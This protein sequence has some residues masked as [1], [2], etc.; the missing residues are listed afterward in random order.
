MD[1]VKAIGQSS[2]V[3]DHHHT[4]ALLLGRAEQHI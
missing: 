1:L 2:V 4:R 3:A